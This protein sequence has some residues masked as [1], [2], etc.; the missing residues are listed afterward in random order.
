MDEAKRRVDGFPQETTGVEE[1]LS[2]NSRPGRSAGGVRAP[3]RRSRPLPVRAPF[4][5]AAC[6][7]TTTTF[8]TM[9]ATDTRQH[10]AAR[11]RDVGELPDHAGDRARPAPDRRRGRARC[12]GESARDPAWSDRDL[13]LQPLRESWAPN[14]DGSVWTFAIRAGATFDDA[15]LTAEDVVATLTSTSR[16]SRWRSRSP[17]SSPPGT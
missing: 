9:G 7:G 16:T 10:R 8:R 5:A 11:R 14:D 3:R 13:M 2:T 17:A 15:L 12:L 1:P 4:I 6:G